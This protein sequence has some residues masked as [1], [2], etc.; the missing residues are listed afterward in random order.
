[1]LDGLSDDVVELTADEVA[2]VL[3]AGPWKGVSK[4]VPSDADLAYVGWEFIKGNG[5]TAVGPPCSAGYGL[6]RL[7][8]PWPPD[9]PT[10]AREPAGP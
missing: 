2:A 5:G 1:V 7:S 4:L 3:D 6:G 8:S 9:P 10:D